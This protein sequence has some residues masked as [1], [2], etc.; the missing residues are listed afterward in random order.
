MYIEFAK[1]RNMVKRAVLIGIDYKNDKRLRLTGC[2]N[3][4]IS[5]RNFL[6]DAYGYNRENI[7]ML[8]DDGVDECIEPTRAN[9]LMEIYNAVNSSRSEDELWIHYS[10]HGTYDYDVN[11]DEVDGRDELIVPVDY[12]T[13]GCIIDDD[14]KKILHLAKCTVCITQDC[15][16]SGT[17]WDLP[18]RVTRDVKSNLLVNRESS[19]LVNKNIYM[20][21]GARDNQY[22]ADTYSSDAARNIGAFTETFM[23]CLR[24]RQHTVAFVELMDDINNELRKTGFEQRSEFT[25]SNMM[26][27]NVII[28]KSGIVNPLVE[29]N[30]NRVIARNNLKTMKFLV[31][32]KY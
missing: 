26:P 22:A 24:N 14:L 12:S 4:A 17:G 15:C 3:D 19:E 32:K 28:T 31:T 30:R 9:I 5:M 13:A 2:I 21:S 23:N 25:T 20:F 27:Q 11:N 8:R 7:S 1:Y 16:H 10:G 18:Y 6:I 29:S